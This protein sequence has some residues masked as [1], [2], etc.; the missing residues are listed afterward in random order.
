MSTSGSFK[1]KGKAMANILAVAGPGSLFQVPGAPAAG[2]WAGLWHG[3]ITPITFIVSLFTPNVR[4]YEI[5]NRGRWYDFGFVI[6]LS[7]SVGGSSH[8]G[9]RLSS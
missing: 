8:G 5:H 4:I 7:A 6:G 2:F 9:C 3:L 1:H